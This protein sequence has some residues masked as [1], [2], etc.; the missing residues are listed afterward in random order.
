MADYCKILAAMRR[1]PI[2]MQAVRH[3]L[4]HYRRGPA[5]KRLAGGE[6][7][8]ARALPRLFEHEARLEEARRSGTAG[9][10]PARH[11]EVLIALV[12]E[13]R[14]LDG[15]RVGEA[16]R[17]DRARAPSRPLSAGNVVTLH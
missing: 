4:V 7:A 16:A 11:V 1:P 15:S 3:G 2:L 12:A 9:Y 13:T 10:S 8:A 17:S 14:R 6:I 5:L